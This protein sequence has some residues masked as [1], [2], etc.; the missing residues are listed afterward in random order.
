LG[1]SFLAT[2][3]TSVGDGFA[4]GARK[5][6]IVNEGEPHFRAEIEARPEKNAY[7]RNP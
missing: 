4:Q 6:P 7:F 1:S 3:G 2:W 5:L